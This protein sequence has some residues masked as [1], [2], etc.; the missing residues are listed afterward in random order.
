M[1]SFPS[2]PIATRGNTQ[3][4]PQPVLDELPIEHRG[5]KGHVVVTGSEFLVNLLIC[6]L[7]DVGRDDPVVVAWDRDGD[8][9]WVCRARVGIK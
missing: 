8:V 6:K 2:N 7:R 9:R 1:L 3:R 4:W 5:M